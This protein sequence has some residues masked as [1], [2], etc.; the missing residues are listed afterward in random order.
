MSNKN[1]DPLKDFDPPK[2][3]IFNN[4]PEFLKYP[5]S[6]NYYTRHI[7]R[8]PVTKETE[9]KTETI[10]ITDIYYKLVNEPDSEYQYAYSKKRVIR[11]KKFLAIGGPMNGQKIPVD[12]YDGDYIPYNLA[13]AGRSKNKLVNIHISLV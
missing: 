4:L 12:Y 11:V 8:P 3:R 1:Q 13:S 5:K 2:K 7:Y 9:N 6:I 10:E